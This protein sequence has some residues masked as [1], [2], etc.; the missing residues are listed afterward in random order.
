MIALLLAIVFGALGAVGLVSAVVMSGLILTT[1]AVLAV[2]ILRDRISTSESRKIVANLP[3]RLTRIDELSQSMAE[4]QKLVEGSAMV[5]A[6]RGSEIQMAHAEARKKTEHWYFKGGTGTYLRAMTLPSCVEAARASRRALVFRV[7]IID[8]INERA[9]ERYENFRRSVSTEPDGTGDTWYRGRAR[10]ES[11]ATVL[12]A[13]WNRQQYQPLDIRIGLTDVV[14]TFRYDMS[15]EYLI[16]TQEDPDH[17]GLLVPRGKPLFDAYGV[18]LHNSFEQTR[19]VPLERADRLPL[20]ADPTADDVR[21]LLE[22]LDLRPEQ[23]LDDQE[24]AIVVQKAFHAKNPY[25]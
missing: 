4:L 8:P 19:L 25:G 22:I 10:L 15:S 20:S 24:A 23:P 7:E 12:A 21:K 3:S 17:P 5:R 2:V 14:S 1:L 9:C 11:F 13:C 6:L 16:V 18:E